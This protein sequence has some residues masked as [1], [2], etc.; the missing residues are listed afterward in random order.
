LSSFG[1]PL[2]LDEAM[3][4]AVT[5]LSGSGPA[6]LAYVIDAMA[7]A[8]AALGLNEADAQR[9]AYRTAL[10]TAS[11]LDEQ[12]F[13]PESLIA[14]VSSAKGTTVAGMAVLRECGIDEAFQRTLAAA[15]ARSRELSG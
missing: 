3:F 5:A 14:A 7:K 2:R 6:F 8:G 1:E 9:L 15:A 12:R 13:T 11:L 10:G 4:D